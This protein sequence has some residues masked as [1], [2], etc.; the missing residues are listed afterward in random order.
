[1]NPNE[2]INITSEK[3]GVTGRIDD[4]GHVIKLIF[5][6]NSLERT[7]GITRPLEGSLAEKGLKTM[8]TAIERLIGT[9]KDVFLSKWYLATENN[10]VTVHGKLTSCPG[11]TDISQIYDTSVLNTE[12]DSE[13]NE[14]I[15]SV[16]DA[17]FRC[18]MRYCHF[19]MQDNEPYLIKDYE[20]LKTQH[21]NKSRNP[22]IE[23]GKVLLVLSD[24]DEYYFHSLCARYDN[25]CIKE[26][27]SSPNIGNYQGNYQTVYGIETYDTAIVLRYYPHFGNIEFYF[28]DTDNLPLYAENIGTRDLYIRLNGMIFCVKP[29]ERKELVIENSEKY[30]HYVL[31]DGDLYPT[32]T[33]IR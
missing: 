31:P 1:M 22:E 19:K 7:I 4:Y 21:L 28:A 29:D 32:G 24:F 33:Q 10:T 17:V 27:Y 5:T 12:L 16:R 30:T 2:S 26:Y 14:M 8:E 25:G 11:Y 15:I 6:Y 23:Q 18:P 9:T 13:K 3:C 20:K